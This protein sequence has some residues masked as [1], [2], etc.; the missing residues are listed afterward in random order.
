MHKY[1]HVCERTSLP[2]SNNPAC[3]DADAL[4]H[5]YAA[6]ASPDARHTTLD[7]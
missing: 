7:V 3:A 6:Y 1:V 4:L 5:A 2:E